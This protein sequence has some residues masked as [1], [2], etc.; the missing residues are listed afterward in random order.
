MLSLS[1]GSFPRA[2]TNIDSDDPYELRQQVLVLKAKMN[3][4]KNKAE[5]AAYEVERRHRC[6]N[7]NARCANADTFTDDWLPG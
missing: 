7:V 2:S 5:Q 3:E 4:Y 6:V 1:L